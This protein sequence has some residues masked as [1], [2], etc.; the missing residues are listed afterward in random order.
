MLEIELKGEIQKLAL[1]PDDALVLKVD[2]HVS[3]D[4]A[5]R[6]HDHLRR[7]FG[8]HRRILILE[9]GMELEVLEPTE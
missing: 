5:E 4:M 8:P 7:Q 9:R 6:I 2:G 3:A 1:Q